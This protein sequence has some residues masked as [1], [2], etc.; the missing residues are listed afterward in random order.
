MGSGGRADT[1]NLPRHGVTLYQFRQRLL[2]AALA[3]I[4]IPAAERII[5]EVSATGHCAYLPT[6]QFEWSKKVE[7]YTPAICAE[8]KS[9]LTEITDI[10]SFQDV[11]EAQRELT[12]DD[13]WKAYVFFV[14]GTA[15]AKNCRQCPDTVIAMNAIPGL[16]NAMFSILSPGKKIPEHRGP[17]KGL[18][19]YHLA[20]VVPDSSDQCA[21]WVNDERR[22]W[23]K[24][25]SLILDDSYP[26]RADNNTNQLRVV[27]FADFERPLPWP[28]SWMNRA[29]IALLRKTD[30]A[31]QPLAQLNSSSTE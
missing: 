2:T 11:S 19:R 1:T 8:L 23:T 13:R 26:H 12:N 16:Q 30:L 24:G 17:Y 31:Q 14:F 9:L 20:L 15:I 6:A 29:V 4:V 28:W 7:Q 27:L 25:K 5:G 3:K 10:P 18:L 21:I 22:T